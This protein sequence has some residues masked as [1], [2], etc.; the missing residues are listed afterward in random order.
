[1]DGASDLVFIIV[2]YN[3]NMEIILEVNTKLSVTLTVE[4]LI[5]N[6][7]RIL[8]PV[9]N[10]SKKNARITISKLKEIGITGELLNKLI[11]TKKRKD[12]KDKLS[13]IYERNL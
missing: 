4:E 6:K 13:E 10:L 2:F 7:K 1:M 3:G 9:G 8:V 11:N 5:N 12:R